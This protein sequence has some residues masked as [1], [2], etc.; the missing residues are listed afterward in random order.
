[1]R[2][3]HAFLA[4]TSPKIDLEIKRTYIALYPILTQL[5][6]V[7]LYLFHLDVVYVVVVVLARSSS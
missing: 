6:C 7:Y 2:H 5:S 3:V 1:M 4:E